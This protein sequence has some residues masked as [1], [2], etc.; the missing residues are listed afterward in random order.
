MVSVSTLTLLAS[1]FTAQA[2]LSGWPDDFGLVKFETY[3]Q[4]LGWWSTTWKMCEGWGDWCNESRCHDLENI[5]VD[6]R[7]IEGI[8]TSNWKW[9][10]ARKSNAAWM[11]LWRGNGD[12]FS[13]FEQNGNGQQQ[14]QC[15]LHNPDPPLGYEKFC[16]DGYRY[17]PIMHCWQW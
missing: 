5:D 15:Q 10:N 1:A 4:N 7:G 6:P 8:L 9:L 12:T 2:K 17:T 13:M 3:I 16:R 11:D 14:G